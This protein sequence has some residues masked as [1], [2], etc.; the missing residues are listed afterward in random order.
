[1]SQRE[2]SE[3]LAAAMEH[4]GWSVAMSMLQEQATEAKEELW[5]LM[6]SKPDELT[7]KKALKLAIRAKALFDFRESL[8][9][10]VKILL[11]QT[12]KGGA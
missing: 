8:I 6:A 10:E 9:D 11:P 3:Q 12:R 7:G 2:R 4:P 1:M 5:A